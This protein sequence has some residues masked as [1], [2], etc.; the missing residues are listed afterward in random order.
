MAGAA[1]SRKTY[2]IE[3]HKEPEGDT[4]TDTESTVNL[5]VIPDGSDFML[6]ISDF[7]DDKVGGAWS[8]DLLICIKL[9]APKAATTREGWKPDNPGV[10][11]RRRN[12]GHQIPPIPSK[13]DGWEPL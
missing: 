8:A 1:G 12:L 9:T 7:P 10:E 2:P 13:R 5:E 4:D 11:Q 6:R 3:T